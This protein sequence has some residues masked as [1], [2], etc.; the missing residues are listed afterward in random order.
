MSRLC[1]LKTKSHG[2]DGLW[3]YNEIVKLRKQRDE[4]LTALEKLMRFTVTEVAHCRGDRCR[5][6]WCASCNTEEDAQ[7]AIDEAYEIYAQADAAIAR[8]KGEAK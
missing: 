7:S 1:R 4:L 2:D 8:V 3:A 6:I 5:E